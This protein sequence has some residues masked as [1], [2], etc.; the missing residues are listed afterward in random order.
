MDDRVQFSTAECFQAALQEF[1]RDKGYGAQAVLAEAV[2]R[3]TKHINDVLHG[4]RS[5]SLDLQERIASHFRM[6]PEEMV[7]LGRRIL[8]EKAGLYPEGADRVPSDPAE[9]ADRVL[10][11]AIGEVGL[12][13]NPFFRDRALKE[14]M[15]EDYEEY[16]SGRMN[17][18]ELYKRTMDQIKTVHD[19]TSRH[20][21]QKKKRERPKK[22]SEGTP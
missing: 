13:G 18:F 16:V 12:A 5:A 1:I 15:P 8:L 11:R 21:N 4:R 6:T 7:S 17:D 3:S 19:K 14:V 2:S 20:F 22:K 10:R 9:R